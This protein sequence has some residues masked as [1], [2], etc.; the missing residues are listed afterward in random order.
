MALSNTVAENHIEYQ[1]DAI[2]LSLLPYGVMR[3]EGATPFSRLG[4]HAKRCL[5]SLEKKSFIQRREFAGDSKR[6]KY[7]QVCIFITG[8]GVAYLAD[9]YSDIYPWLPFLAENELIKN[10][11]FSIRSIM[12]NHSFNR[13]LNCQYSDVFF[14]ESGV[15]TIFERLQ[16]IPTDVADVIEM[17]T[18]AMPEDYFPKL[19]AEAIKEWGKLNSSEVSCPHYDVR[20]YD[21]WEISCGSNCPYNRSNHPKDGFYIDLVKYRLGHIGLLQGKYSNFV[22][23][24]AKRDGVRLNPAVLT[25]CHDSVANQM[26]DLGII[27]SISNTPSLFQII[28]LCNT[29]GT[30]VSTFKHAFLD[31]RNLRP[32]SSKLLGIGTSATYLVPITSKAFT[33]ALALSGTANYES[34]WIRLLSENFHAVE[35]NSRS[36]DFPLTYKDKPCAFGM[37]LNA[38]HLNQCIENQQN[39]A[40]ICHEWQV[41]FVR[42]V[43]PN[44][45][46]VG[47][48]AETHTLTE[49]LPQG[50]KSGNPS[51]A[52]P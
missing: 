9:K 49:H 19:C 5:D 34:T 25:R 36:I 1:R 30:G 28:V 10:N 33:F 40:V 24:M 52:N 14:S 37:S 17:A 15:E 8:A 4:K 23:M 45:L 44:I 21:S 27:S 50:T 11:S 3:K 31:N 20:F 22:V 26:L 41:P 7:K 51:S 39:K 35:R 16:Y 38:L 6:R 46:I 13:I 32:K 2:L 48:D 18:E 43:L 42:S 12:G 47:H 29:S